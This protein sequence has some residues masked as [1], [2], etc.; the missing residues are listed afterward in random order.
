MSDRKDFFISYTQ[1]DRQKAEWISWQLEGAGFTVVI[2]AWDFL[3]GDNFVH[4]M[5]EASSQCERTIAV[6]SPDYLQSAFCKLEWAAAFAQDPTSER[7][8][9]LF[10]RVRECELPSLL[11]PNVYIDFLNTTEEEA[12]TLLLAGVKRER[13][14]PL[15]PPPFSLFTSTIPSR[16]RSPG[17]LPG[18]WNINQHENPHFF[19]REEL[20][21]AVHQRLHAGEAVV[22]AGLGGVG[23]TQFAIKYAYQYAAEYNA[24]WWVKAEEEIILL[25]DLVELAKEFELPCVSTGET[26]TILMEVKR[27]LNTVSGWLLVF[28][29]APSDM[30]VR[31]Y[32][33]QNRSGHLLITS[34]DQSWSVGR[35]IEIKGFSANEAEAFLLQRTAQP[36][37]VAARKIAQELGHLPLALEQAGAYISKSKKQL[38]DYSLLL[39]RRR[40]ELL[41]RGQPA[42]YANTVATT[43]DISLEAVYKQ[44]SAVAELLRVCAYLGSDDIPLSALQIGKAY[45]PDVLAAAIEDEFEMDEVIEALLHYSLISLHEHRLSVHRLVQ[46]VTRDR[47]TQGDQEFYAQAAVG[48]VNEAIAQQNPQEQ[49]SALLPHALAAAAHGERLNVPDDELARLGRSINNAILEIGIGDVLRTALPGSQLKLTCA[50]LIFWE[51]YLDNEEPLFDE[52]ERLYRETIEVRESELGRNHEDVAEALTKLLNFLIRK[53][54]IEEARPIFERIQ[55]MNFTRSH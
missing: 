10:V 45:L 49:L 5:Q 11:K 7:G 23:K 13:A 37:I 35:P 16:S 17:G 54:R 26:S 52:A 50:D 1:A 19:G 44:S 39:Q 46:M 51:A 4:K 24:I 22:L 6:L 36:N 12:R 15:A 18:I 53:Q 33:P 43:W 38:E 3:P 9:L 29:N 20:L 25:S 28:D 55:K 14:K 31:T 41:R 2:Q 40:S 32:L 48:I 27:K 21:T 34:R 30:K 8:L 47:L 42:E